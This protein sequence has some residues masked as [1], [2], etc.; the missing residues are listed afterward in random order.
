MARTARTVT[1]PSSSR[2]ITAGA[3]GSGGAVEINGRRPGGATAAAGAAPSTG[4]ATGAG[5]STVAGSAEPCARAGRAAA[6][7]VAAMHT[8][9]TRRQRGTKGPQVWHE[10]LPR[11]CRDLSPGRRGQRQLLQARGGLRHVQVAL[12]VGGDL[13]AAVSQPGGLDR[14]GERQRLAVD[15]RDLVA[16]AH[17]EEPLVAIG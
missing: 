17:V 3:T 13:M 2:V 15:D 14:P 9:D 11:L 10:G 4:E 16:V 1:L 7:A 12:G 8:S 6:S 5:A